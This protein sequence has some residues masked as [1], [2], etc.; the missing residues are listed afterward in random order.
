M[1]GLCVHPA[2]INTVYV[3]LTLPEQSGDEFVSWNSISGT[4]NGKN[5]EAVTPSG[6]ASSG[7]ADEVEPKLIFKYDFDRYHFAPILDCFDDFQIF[8][9]IYLDHVQVLPTAEAMLPA[10]CKAQCD[11]IGVVFGQHNVIFIF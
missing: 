5:A 7:S 9:Y 8:S 10:Y 4:V 6:Y 11:A 2:D 3:K 1:C